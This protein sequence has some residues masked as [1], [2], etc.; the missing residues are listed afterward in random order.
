MTVPVGRAPLPRRSILSRLSPCPGGR[1]WRTPGLLLVA[2][3]AAAPL[4]AP[5]RAGTLLE[6]SIRQGQLVMAG[7]ADT[8]PFVTLSASG[9]PVGYAIGIGKLIDAALAD[10]TGRKLQLRYE[11]LA[12]SNAVVKAVTA[13]QAALA[14]GVP[15]SWERDRQVDYSL[16]IA[17]S[18]LR[19]LVRP[20]GPDGA[21]AGLAG[22][23]VAVV[24]GTL[25]ESFLTGLQVAAKP[26]PFASYGDAVT[27]L[28]QGRVAAVLG[29]TLVLRGVRQQLKLNSLQTV[30]SIPYTRYGV[31]CIV[32][33]NN[34]D[35]LNVV[36]FAIARMMQAYVD[37]QPQAVAFV[38]RWFGQSGLQVDSSQIRTYFQNVLITRESLKLQGLPFPLANP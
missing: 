3:L 25:G 36:N 24:K 10:L 1:V 18:G 12:N 16:P 20:G 30:P 37:G 34:S 21:P 38:D 5:A 2:A 8:P 7:S 19:L 31:G 27:A 14:C 11:S 29:D 4:T 32:P 28:E 22:Q 15:F 9:E 13:G 33:E 35:F 23:R 26:V 17:L 6:Q